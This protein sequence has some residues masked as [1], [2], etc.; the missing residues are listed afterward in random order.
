LDVDFV[1]NVRREAVSALSPGAKQGAIP[2]PDPSLVDQQNNSADRQTTLA[3]DVRGA[4]SL[5]F[6]RGVRYDRNA[7]AFDRSTPRS[8]QPAR[9]R[10]K[11]RG[12]GAQDFAI[13]RTRPCSA[14]P[15]AVLNRGSPRDR[16][17][18]FR[19]SFQTGDTRGVSSTVAAI[20]VV[21][22]DH[23]T[24]EVLRQKF[25]SLVVLEQL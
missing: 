7:D 1:S 3:G 4:A 13:R 16:I 21:G 17:A 8:V 9:H 24:G 20:D 12:L 22:A 14:T 23:G 6:V 15:L 18:S 5:T 10:R 25:S 19:T 11:M 2:L